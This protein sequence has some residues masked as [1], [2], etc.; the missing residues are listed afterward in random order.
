MPEDRHRRHR[1]AIR[2]R[3]ASEATRWTLTLDP[4]K[5]FGPTDGA[6]VSKRVARVPVNF[7]GRGRSGLCRACPGDSA[8]DG[9]VSPATYT[10]PP[11]TVM[12]GSAAVFGAEPAT[13]F[14][15]I[16]A[17]IMAGPWA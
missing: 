2:T 11:L 8:A 17:R 10:A 9:A 3:T 7:R 12:S 13:G 6:S 15:C 16:T 1:R 5:A 14:G 4:A